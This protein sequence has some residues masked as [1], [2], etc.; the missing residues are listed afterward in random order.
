MREIYADFND[1]DSDGFLPLTCSGS[2]HCIA[3]LTER[4]VDGE[5]VWLTDGALRVSANVFLGDAGWWEA[6]SQ[7][8]FERVK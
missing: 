3:G 7:W 2:M 8:K 4:L 6:R 5:E 1:I